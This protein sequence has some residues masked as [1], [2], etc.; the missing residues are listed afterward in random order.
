MRSRLLAACAA[1]LLGFPILAHAQP[2]APSVSL[3]DPDPPGWDA[4]GQVAW[5]TVDKGAIAPDWNRW[6][7]AATFGASVGKFVGRHVKLEFDVATSTEAEVFSD[8]LVRLPPAGTLVSVGQP[9]HFR[10]TTVSAGAAYQFFDNRWFHPVVGGGMESARETRTIGPVLYPVVPP[11]T[12]PDPGTT[13]TW[14]TRPFVAAGFKLYF[15]ERGFMRSDVRTTFD[16]DG[17][18][19]VSW[20]TGIGFDF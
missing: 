16:R 12:V 20:R 18:A 1:V 2:P 4:S 8:Q 3:G 10:M 7:D 6:Y 19:Q 17:V 14:Q 5:L 13:V 15:T 11:I 9:N